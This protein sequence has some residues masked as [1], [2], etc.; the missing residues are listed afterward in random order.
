MSKRNKKV[1][2]PHIKAGRLFI[3]IGLIMIGIF[4][5]QM[6][7]ESRY[8]EKYDKVEATIMQINSDVSNREIDRGEITHSALIEYTYNGEYYDYISL[9][10]FRSSMREGQK[11]TIYLKPSAPRDPITKMGTGFFLAYIGIG[12][13][14]L[15]IGVSTI[16]VGGMSNKKRL[17]DKGQGEQVYAT[18]TYAGKTSLTINDKRVYRVNATWVDPNG[19]THELKSDAL[20]FDPSVYIGEGDTIKV[21]VDPKNYK[22][23]YMCAKELQSGGNE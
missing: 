14:V 5:G 20:Y 9:G 13:L 16:V 21:Y 22:K 17:V 10:S 8:D 12:T 6:F 11:V 3:I 7:A 4:G 15:F 18:V 23:Y 2:P 19:I 1:T